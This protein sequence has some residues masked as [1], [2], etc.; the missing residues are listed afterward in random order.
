MKQV[1]FLDGIGPQALPILAEAGIGAIEAKRGF[2]NDMA[3]LRQFIEESFVPGE[4]AVVCLRSGTNLSASILPFLRDQGVSLIVRFG[5]G[6]DNISDQT[7]T[8]KVEA[9]K[10]GIV[11]ENT[12]GQNANGVAELVKAFTLMLPRRIGFILRQQAL[13]QPIAKT[14]CQGTEVLAK[15]MGVIGLGWVGSQVARKAIGLGMTV[16]GHDTR[17][18]IEVEDV[19][20]VALD[21]LLAQSDFI[22]IHVPLSPET[23][24]LIGA[25]QIAAMAKRPFLINCARAGIV[26]LRAVEAGIKSGQIAGYASDVDDPTDN[27]FSLSDTIV[28]PHIGASTKESEERCAI[29]GARQVVIWLRQGAIQ[30]GVNL[31]DDVITG[32]KNGRL[33]VIHW[34]RPGVISSITNTVPGNIGVFS[35]KSHDGSNLACA[36]LG[37]DQ[38]FDPLLVEQLS[39]LPNVI[40]VIAIN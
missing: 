28:T 36:M 9:G 14:E 12:P 22:S 24:S 21:T 5:S 30:N 16:L 33:L 23:E 25:T 11:V 17:A 18:E 8:F 29:M 13:G 27:I 6:V 34:N 38:R 40:R 15:T 26:N 10:L 20:R 3:A 35:C 4:L 1:L 39:G 2:G 32:C 7:D 31:T 19:S 37:P